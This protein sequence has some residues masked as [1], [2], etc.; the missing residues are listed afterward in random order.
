LIINGDKIDVHP[1][2]IYLIRT[3]GLSFKNEHLNSKKSTIMD[4]SLFSSMIQETHIHT[5]KLSFVNKHIIVWSRW[6]KS[7]G[8]DQNDKTPAIFFIFHL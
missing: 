5:T 8:G 4:D 2:R 7:R 3:F 1:Q 6:E